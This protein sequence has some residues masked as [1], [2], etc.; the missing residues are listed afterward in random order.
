[1]SKALLF[2]RATDEAKRDALF[3]SRSNIQRRVTLRISPMQFD[4]SPFFHLQGD[5]S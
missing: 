1:V 5:A 4:L 2:F 3:T